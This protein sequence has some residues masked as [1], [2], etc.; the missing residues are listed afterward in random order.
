MKG[1]LDGIVG[2]MVE[3]KKIHMPSA[4]KAE[5]P[6]TGTID[7][8][9]IEGLNKRQE[10]LTIKLMEVY[11]N[12]VGR[13]IDSSQGA[14]AKTMETVA[15]LQD[16]LNHWIAEHGEVYAEGIQT[17]MNPKKARVYDS[18][19]NWTVIDLLSTYHELATGRFKGGH[20]EISQISES[21]ANRSS[22][23]LSDV[24]VHLASKTEP[25]RHAADTF[26]WDT[27]KKCR[28]SWAKEPVFRSQIAF[29]S[30]KTIIDENGSIRVSEVAR[31]GTK[32][33]M[34]YINEMRAVRSY[35]NEETPIIYIK[36]KGKGGWGFNKDTTNL[37]FEE[38][39]AAAAD[40]KSFSGRSALLIGA[41]PGSI[42]SEV[43]AGLL[44]GGAQVV[45]TT[46]SFSP[47]TTQ[48]F[49]RSLLEK[50]KPNGQA[51]PGT[52]QSG[53]RTRCREA[54]CHGF[55]VRRTAWA[56]I[57]TLSSLSGRSVR[58]TEILTPLILGASWLTASCLRTQSVSL[59][60]SSGMS[61]AASLTVALHT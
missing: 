56:G 28:A 31:E 19:W 30:P 37:Y 1:F 4:H 33:L 60:A 26:L 22:P 48:F 15:R 7:P 11:A 35:G 10:A 57:W 53:K 17:A 49:Q 41:G 59:E 2:A 42:G 46:S 43:L 50:W 5:G 39:D 6:R 27:L 34:D 16:Q 9:V 51:G 23:T 24:L 25:T 40:G 47:A 36:S 8:K 44:R 38:L 12:S 52:F 29:T 21:I 20:L 14:S 58:R 13:S 61:A 45:V 32:C 54:R 3:E 18:S 55:T